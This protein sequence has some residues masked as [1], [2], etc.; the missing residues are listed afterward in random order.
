M[1][2]DLISWQLIFVAFI[3]FTYVGTT[4]EFTSFKDVMAILMPIGLLVGC[5]FISYGTGNL[6]TDWR[7]SG[8]EFID[9][10]LWFSISFAVIITLHVGVVQLLSHAPFSVTFSIMDMA[11]YLMFISVVEE[12]AFRGCMLPF[13]AMLTPTLGF[14][15]A[16]P[17]SAGAWTL[18]HSTVYGTNPLAL[19]M[20][21]MVGIVLG[22][23]AW[24]KRRLWITM[25]AH[26]LANLLAWTVGT[27]VGTMIPVFV[28]TLLVLLWFYYRRK[29]RG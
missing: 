4:Q 1:I 12:I 29:G 14:F 7:L 28:I 6:K 18:Y 5:G 15:L 24:Y 17:F 21:L 10:L 9:G 11:L 27:W 23:I 16:V 13:F 25:G 19:I 8:K 20:V 26:M 22:F 2:L 3:C